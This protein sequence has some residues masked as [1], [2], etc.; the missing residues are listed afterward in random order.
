M[1]ATRIALCADD[2]GLGTHVT[3]GVM[4]LVERG[5]LNAVGCMVGAPGWPAASAE[6]GALAAAGVDVGLHLDLTEHPIDAQWRG[7]LARLIA[8][9]HARQLNALS[10]HAE[11][12]QQIDRFVQ[13][14]GRAPD[15]IDGHRH[16]HQLPQV[17]VALLDMI[18]RRGL[19]PW[20]RS[21]RRPTRLRP[22]AG[23]ALADRVKPWLIETLGAEALAEGAARAGLTQNR[24][25]LGVYGFNADAAGYRRWIEAWLAAAR[26]SDLLMCHPA[27]G[28]DDTLTDTI[29]AARGVEQTVLASAWMLE[30]MAHHATR[31]V[32]LGDSLR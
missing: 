30:T 22:P 16:V 12:E 24:G 15:Y 19:R 23:T 7:G 18:A 31:S 14:V 10:L 20:L 11:I 1:T 32:R 8:R 29:A 28:R 4:A 3:R 2:F 13:Q 6:V 17:R 27:L 9:S 25:L 5:R 21:T 26:D